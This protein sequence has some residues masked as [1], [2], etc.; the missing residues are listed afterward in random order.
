MGGDGVIDRI[1]EALRAMLEDPSGAVR[2][3][4]AA[5]LD[6][7]RARR[8]AGSLQ[9]GLACGSLSLEERVR[10][11]FVAEEVG[12]PEGLSLLLT[13]L[14]DPDAEVRAAAARALEGFP[15][16]SVLKAMVRRLSRE[17]G[18]VLGN[19]IESLGKSHRKELSPILERFMDHPDDEVRGRAIVAY[20][21]VAG[22]AG[23]EKILPRAENASE[24]VRAAVARALAECSGS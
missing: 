24:T 5:A 17:T 14:E 4:A 6:R 18:V 10:A 12:G 8:A 22:P 23:W 15:T 21:C 19:L 2:E 9:E 1:E 11:V 13:A 20:A 7:V 3:A 16:P